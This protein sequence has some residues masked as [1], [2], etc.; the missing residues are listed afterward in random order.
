MN[1][2]DARS[3]QREAEELRAYGPFMKQQ[4]LDL[5]GLRKFR[6]E[7]QK[8]QKDAA[9]LRSI[10]IEE[11]EEAKAIDEQLRK[12]KKPKPEEVKALVAKLD[13]TRERFDQKKRPIRDRL[14]GK[15]D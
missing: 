8:R 10:Q 5:E 14:F 1:D 3:K 2:D 9:L 7:I 13:E 6:E 12:M 4:G 15:K 11:A